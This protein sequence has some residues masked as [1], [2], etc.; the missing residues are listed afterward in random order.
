MNTTMSSSIAHLAMALS[1]FQSV[2]ENVD[3]DKQAYGY[4]YADLS[5]C[6]EA[7]KAPLAKNGLSIIQPIQMLEDKHIL[8]TYLIH[9]TGEWMKSCFCMATIP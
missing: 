3:K 6:L 1:K 8:E 4:K 2:I 7:I 5:T 9:E